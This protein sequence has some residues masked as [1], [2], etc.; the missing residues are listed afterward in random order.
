VWCLQVLLY[1][2]LI[3]LNPRNC[4]NHFDDSLFTTLFPVDTISSHPFKCTSCGT[5]ARVCPVKSRDGERKDVKKT[6]LRILSRLYAFLPGCSDP[7]GAKDRKT[8]RYRN[9]SVTIVDMKNS[10]VNNRKI[11]F[12]MYLYAAYRRGCCCEPQWNVPNPSTMARALI[13]ITSLSGKRF[14]MIR[15]ASASCGSLNT[16]TITT[17]FPI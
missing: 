6:P 16:G 15:R 5:C 8:G 4:E 1:V 14:W 10:A 3:I 12:L 9:P 7:A 11:I 17:E 13:P 2:I